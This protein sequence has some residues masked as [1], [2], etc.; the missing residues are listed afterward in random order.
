MGACDGT[1]YSG[2]QCCKLCNGTVELLVTTSVGPRII[3][4][5]FPGQENILG[6]C[7]DAV[8]STELGSRPSWA[9][10]SPT[11]AI[12]SGTRPSPS[13]APTCPTTGRSRP[14]ARA[15]RSI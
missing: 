1:E 15:G 3:R 5:G 10:G 8:V 13:P 14:A 9:T 2:Y 11:A 4:Y 6:E 7:P 12:A